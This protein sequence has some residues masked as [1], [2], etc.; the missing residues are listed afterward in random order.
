MPFSSLLSSQLQRVHSDTM[1]SPLS[2]LSTS[3]SFLCSQNQPKQRCKV[4][5]SVMPQ[6]GYMAW[7]CFW[8]PWV[9]LSSGRRLLSG[10]QGLGWV[11]HCNHYQVK[12][13]KVAWVFVTSTTILPMWVSYW[14]RKLTKKV[15]NSVVRENYLRVLS[16]KTRHV[17]RQNWHVHLNIL[18]LGRIWAL[19]RAEQRLAHWRLPVGVLSGSLVFC[20]SLLLHQ[21]RFFLTYPS[22]AQWKQSCV[23]ESTQSRFLWS[24]RALLV[25][26]R[27]REKNSDGFAGV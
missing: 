6:H 16:I 26:L 23:A 18:L 24:F 10:Q 11:Q 9:C 17:V 14:V 21:L 7:L 20:Y 1:G 22:S 3:C 5:D 2:T 13:N 27:G 8:T 4:R 12:S 25:A 19:K 15:W